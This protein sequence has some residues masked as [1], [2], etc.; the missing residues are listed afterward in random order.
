MTTEAE[1]RKTVTDLESK[2]ALSNAQAKR[3]MMDHEK[4]RQA[5]ESVEIRVGG[6][7]NDYAKQVEYL[8]EIKKR[9]DEQ[10]HRLTI[11]SREKGWE[12]ERLKREIEYL[13]ARIIAA[14]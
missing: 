8:T 3:I 9:Q 11:A 1:W 13:R 14:L 12:I 7:M 5:W 2:L 10:I 6:W 4:E